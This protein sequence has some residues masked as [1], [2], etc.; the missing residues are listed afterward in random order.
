[1]R[2]TIADANQSS[3]H[4]ADLVYLALLGMAEGLVTFFAVWTL[5][6]HAVIALGASFSTLRQLAP[7]ALATAALAGLLLARVRYRAAAPS[8]EAA[9][10]A[11]APALPWFVYAGTGAALVFLY[12]VSG[13]YLVF[14]TLAIAFLG[15]A[16]VFARKHAY[17]SV[18]CTPPVAGGQLAVLLASM[19]FVVMYVLYLD[20]ANLDDPLYLNFIVGMLQHPDWPLFRFDTMHGI[21]GLPVQNTAYAVSSLEPMQAVISTWTGTAP[22]WLRQFL[23]A[24]LSAI[25]SVLFVAALCRRLLPRHWPGV[26]VTYLGLILVWAEGFRSIGSFHF[27]YLSTGKHVLVAVLVPALVHA[28]LAWSRNGRALDWLLLAAGNVAAVGLTPNAIYVAPLA[29]GLVLLADAPIDG[30]GFKRLVLGGLAAVYPAACGIVLMVATS[31]GASEVLET[32][33]IEESLRTSLG[34]DMRYWLFWAVVLGGWAALPQGRD[35]RLLA[36]WLLAFL[37]ILGN[38][39]LPELWG[40]HVT[41]NLNWR[42][43]WAV[44]VILLLSVTLHALIGAVCRAPACG[45]VPAV[46]VLAWLIANPTDDLRQVSLDLGKVEL[47][48]PQPEY[49]IAGM[50]ADRL[51]PEDRILAPKEIAAYV[52]TFMDHP[53]PL[54]ARPLYLFHY[55]N[56][57][58]PEELLRR[59]ALYALVAPTDLGQGAMGKLVSFLVEQKLVPDEETLTALG[60][61]YLTEALSRKEFAAVVFRTGS[62]CAGQFAEHLTRA[63]FQSVQ[64]GGFQLWFAR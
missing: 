20:N 38:P 7:F 48:V 63:G 55:R 61:S 11:S 8:I 16:L 24:P 35:A 25:M 32:E 6:V 18:E 23:F 42:L 5:V 37:V 49:R 41:G 57:I 53:Y 1:M 33:S 31:V 50:L 9:A 54:V 60:A 13:S 14:W 62:N 46:L 21:D 27:D 34:W 43:V 22:I 4:R 45:W 44:P 30:P 10:P 29:T 2:R 28:A 15:F 40:E 12:R 52:A 17:P 58:P 36:S 59:A 39:L 3:P 26:L 56:V 19:A 64:H 51:T 47:K